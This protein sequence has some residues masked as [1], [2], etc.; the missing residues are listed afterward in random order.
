MDLPTSLKDWVDMVATGGGVAGALIV[1]AI[2]ARTSREELRRK[3]AEAGRSLIT[4]MCDDREAKNAFAILDMEDDDGSL[5]VLRDETG[6]AV[7]VDW[8]TVV[9][10]LDDARIANTGQLVREAF[11]ALFYYFALFGHCI[12]SKLV[13]L[14]DVGYPASYY[15]EI[16]GRA[17]IREPFVA[18][19]RR[20]RLVQAEH[21]LN[22]WPE[23]SRS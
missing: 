7:T 11:D 2:N 17:D 23:W 20:Y 9:T 12:D 3:H 21:F 6:K 16:L 10:A 13:R 4:E 15:I 14:E 19:L 8:D 5:A 18:Y 22:R 1:F